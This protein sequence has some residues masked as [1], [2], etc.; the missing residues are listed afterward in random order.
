MTATRLNIKDYQSWRCQ[1]INFQAVL[2][3][4]SLASAV[5]FFYSN[6]VWHLIP[7][8][9]DIWIK[10]GNKCLQAS[11]IIHQN[12]I[13]LPFVIFR[14]YFSTTLSIKWLLICRWHFKEKSRKMKIKF[15]WHFI[16]YHPFRSTLKAICGTRNFIK[17]FQIASNVSCTQK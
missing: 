13:L 6:F 4:T 16:C 17:Y 15:S 5:V 2:N 11:T 7:S 12:S 3:F 1:I 14:L 8:L 9:D 10:I